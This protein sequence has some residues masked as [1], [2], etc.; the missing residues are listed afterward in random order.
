M[1]I[2]LVT[3]FQDDNVGTCLQA[4]ALQK[5][6][7]E[8]GHHV[9]II[10]Y[11]HQDIVEKDKSLNNKI[12]G[13]I[14]TYCNRN[15]FYYKKL[16]NVDFIT[17]QNF[18]RFRDAYLSISPEEYVE[19]NQIVECNKDY[20]AFICGS[21]MIWTPTFQIDH[22]IYF[23]QFCDPDKRIAYAPSFGADKIPPEL[24][25]KYQKYICSIKYISCR[26]DSGVRLIRELAD[27]KAELVLDP[28][29]LISK[30]MWEKTF[31][32]RGSKE[33]YILCYLFAASQDVT[34]WYKELAKEI[35]EHLNVKIRFMPMNRTEQVHELHFADASYGPAEFLNLIYNAEFVVT[36]SYHGFMFSLI[37]EKPFVVVRREKELYWS[38]FEKRFESVLQSIHQ[39]QRLL[40]IGAAM[41]EGLYSIDYKRINES[42]MLQRQRSEAYLCNALKQI[43]HKNTEKI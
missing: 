2:G 25:K 21:D 42:L 17:K 27:R 18:Q 7:Q 35:S 26:E 30:N 32:Q 11:S 19:F 22:R 34:D 40:E 14:K 37:F 6:L 1:R 12:K 41:D 24:E 23:L 5:K 10:N 43:E 29:Q 16:K 9:E 38:Q 3:F 15:I 31:A 33:N 4:F 8:L 13:I 20:D 36:N 39:E 28:T